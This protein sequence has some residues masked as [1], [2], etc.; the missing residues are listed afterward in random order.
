M[1]K[2]G[3]FLLA[4]CFTMGLSV[5]VQATA[6]DLND[7]FADP[8][9]TVA[10]D[11]S[12][13]LMEEDQN[14][15]TVL[16]SNDP[17]LGDPDIITAGTAPN[18]L[19]F[20]FDFVEPAGNDDEFGAFVLDSSGVSVGPAFEF[21][22]QTPGSGTVTFDISLSALPPLP[23]GPFG[24]QFQLSSLFDDAAF[25]SKVTISNVRIVPE[26]GSLLL[27]SAGFGTLLF[28]RRRSKGQAASAS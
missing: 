26:P 12:S 1:N 16:L 22:T 17:G 15:F 10:V 28:R 21:F 24:L 23:G 11:G 5:S 2:L 6:I 18:F 20:D 27:F 19:I 14:L 7:F 13:A 3:V 25:D 8:T 9:V 4:V